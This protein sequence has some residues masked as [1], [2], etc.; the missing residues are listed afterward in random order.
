[1]DENGNVYPSNYYITEEQ[2]LEGDYTSYEYV[3]GE[4]GEETAEMHF[5][6]ESYADDYQIK[7]YI[8]AETG[9]ASYANHVSVFEIPEGTSVDAET[10]VT[11]ANYSYGHGGGKQFYI[12]DEESEKLETVD[13]DYVVDN[14]EVYSGAA[15]EMEK[16][17]T[18]VSLVNNAVGSGPEDEEINGAPPGADEIEKEDASKE[19]INGA[20]PDED[21]EDLAAK[22]LAGGSFENEDG[23]EDIQSGNN[24]SGPSEDD[25]LDL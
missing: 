13:E 19:E 2:L 18:E 12:S 24:G 20:A 6:A 3:T 16:K 1:M 14:R 11:D 22:N 15:K 7:P 17:G 9:E 10:G 25:G 5:D 8:N 4:D 23:G 21:N